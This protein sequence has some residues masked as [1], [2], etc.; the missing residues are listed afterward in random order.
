MSPRKELLVVE[1]RCI[2]CGECRQACPFGQTIAGAGVLP[3]RNP[4]CTHCG[5]CVDACPTGARQMVGREMSVAEVTTEILQDR[6]FFE[7]SGGGVTI[8]GGE[9]LT[10]FSFLRELLESCRA[11]DLHTAVDTCGF[12][13]TDHLLTVARLSDLVLYDLK[14]LDGARHRQHTG[15]SNASIL[16]NLKALDQIHQNIWLR[17]PI[18][19][20]VNDDEVNLAAIGRFASTLHGIRQVNLL[21]YHKTG[22]QKHRRLGS[23]Y[24]LE[25]VQPPAPERMAQ[26]AESFRAFGLKA[27]VGGA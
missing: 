26:I 19:P 14:F 8:S 13:C 4:P 25:G 20:G 3:T 1:S 10:Q 15:V 5:E 12:G 17:V 11:R 23:P 18:I 7:E 24:L 2:V 16:E 21:A 6:I 9:P 22:I 27:K